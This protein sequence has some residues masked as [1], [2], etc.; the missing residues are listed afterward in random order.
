MG[1]MDILMF[2]ESFKC[3]RI[4]VE[5]SSPIIECVFTIRQLLSDFRR[6][7]VD[8]SERSSTFIRNSF[9]CPLSGSPS[10]VRLCRSCLRRFGN[11]KKNTHLEFGSMTLVDVVVFYWFHGLPSSVR[12]CR[13]CQRRF[14]G[15]RNSHAPG[16]LEHVSCG[17]SQCSSILGSPHR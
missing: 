12:L 11:L 8:F 16:L 9:K 1:Y 15:L 14:G 17:S 2:N 10:P 3:H 4:L 6:L 5:L 7:F 13:S